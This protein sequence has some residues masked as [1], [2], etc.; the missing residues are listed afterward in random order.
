MKKFEEKIDSDLR[1]YSQPLSIITNNEPSID[2]WIDFPLLDDEGLQVVEEK[3]KNNP[4]Y[5]SD[6]VKT[7][8]YNILC[9]IKKP[10]FFF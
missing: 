1:N 4:S 8:Y 7:Y 5:K 3:L 2:I 10:P 9:K 6:L